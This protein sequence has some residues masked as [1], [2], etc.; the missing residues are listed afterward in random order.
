MDCKFLSNGIAIQYHNFLKPCCAWRGDDQWVK[1]H[2]L[3]SVDIVNWHDHKDLVEAREK[4]AQNQWPDPCVECKTIEE[5]GR[6][7]S[8]RL[9]S[10][11]AYSDFSRD[12]ITLEIRPG[13]VCNFA[14]QTCWTPASTRVAEFY[15]K[16][17]I[18]DPFANFVKNDLTNFDFLL[19]VSQRLKKIIILGGEPF[20]DP[21]CLDFLQW[22][23][24]NTSAELM[25]FTNGSVVDLELL[26]NSN[27]KFTLI[28]SLDAVGRP[29]EYIRFGTA[30]DQ[31]INNFNLVR[32]LNNVEVRVNITT[33][34]YNFY[35]FADVIDLLIPNWPSVVSF[36]PAMED[37][38]SERVIPLEQRQL[39]I[40]RLQQ[41]VDNINK[42]NIEAGQKSN[43]LN[44]VQAIINNLNKA[45]Y[46]PDLHE[47]F[48]TF[49][50]RMDAV[51]KVNLQDFCPEISSLIA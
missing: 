19:P 12:D 5:Q 23:L 10:A 27:R 4:L 16:A 39:I 34:V 47:Q 25:A 33:S 42:A 45:V 7:D 30:W 51:K 17:G 26:S 35:Y 50:E 9:N 36:G 3:K 24:A 48:K 8:M 38:Y 11:S 18:P 2:D 13:N 49:V 22:C 28:F 44:A 15:R 40:K 14:C 20:Y 32:N 46:D 31:V 37:I 1:D 21:K 6:Q 43:A 29:A 41:C